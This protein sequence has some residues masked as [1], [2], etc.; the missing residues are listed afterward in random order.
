MHLVHFHRANGVLNGDSAFELDFQVF[1]RIINIK[2]IAIVADFKSKSYNSAVESDLF[3]L[4]KQ[5]KP[6]YNDLIQKKN[7]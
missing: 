2:C 6:M 3:K 7:T 1:S 4:R 5:M